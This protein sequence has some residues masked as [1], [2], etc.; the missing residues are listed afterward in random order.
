MCAW[1][2]LEE[3]MGDEGLTDLVLGFVEQGLMGVVGAQLVRGVGAR[4]EVLWAMKGLDWP[5][6][7]EVRETAAEVLWAMEGLEWP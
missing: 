1:E 4:A 7:A 3:G 5:P 2:E 6:R